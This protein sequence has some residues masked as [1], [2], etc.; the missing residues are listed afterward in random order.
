MACRDRH[1]RSQDD[2]SVDGGRRAVR[3][4]IFAAPCLA[5]DQLKTDGGHLTL[6][7]LRT[8]AAARVVNR[9]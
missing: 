8:A 5:N 6:D 3:S 1:L 4:R 2:L 9:S 7:A